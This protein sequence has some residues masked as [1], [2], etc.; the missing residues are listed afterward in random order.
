MPA[1]FVLPLLAIP[2]QVQPLNWPTSPPGR[3]GAE[4]LRSPPQDFLLEPCVLQFELLF[5]KP[6]RAA[7]LST[8]DPATQHLLPVATHSFIFQPSSLGSHGEPPI[9]AASLRLRTLSV[10]LPL[11]STK[12]DCAPL[13]FL[14]NP[15]LS[16]LLQTT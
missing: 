8:P 16:S 3:P 7:Q 13:S 1:G 4:P 5:Q 6:R 12:P 14:P 10:A 2:S 11:T 9:T 15:I